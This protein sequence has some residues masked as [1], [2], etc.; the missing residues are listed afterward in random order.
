MGQIKVYADV[1]GIEGL[2]LLEPRLFKDNRGYLFEAF[3][4]KELLN[5]G[6]D[7]DFVQ[8][9]EAYSKKGTLRGFG[10][11]I[12]SPQGKLI[13][14]IGGKIYD[15]VIDL[16]KNSNTFLKS[17]TVILSSENYRQLYIP[18]GF[19][20]AYYALE[21]S[22]VLFKVTTHFVPG[23]E[24]GFAWN[25]KIFSIDWPIANCNTLIMSD[26]DRNN[27]EFNISMLE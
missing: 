24:I 17:Y 8:D 9:N 4:K 15:V 16:R 27:P 23:G 3:N 1:G 6:L 13:R 7:L 12:K 20:H 10:I 11:S 5:A 18:E 22:V 2:C 25:S 21:D 14:V 26:I 19:A